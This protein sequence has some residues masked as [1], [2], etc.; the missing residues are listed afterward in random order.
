MIR[1]AVLLDTSFFLRFLNENDPLFKNNDGYFRYF[2]EKEFVLVIST[3]S[4]AEYCVGGSIE[5]LPLKN[6][7]I[8]PFNL[9]HAKR[10][11]EFA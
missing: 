10:T 4:I 11:G 3:V 5:Q 9:D 2:L 8:L 7:K 1:R 6:L